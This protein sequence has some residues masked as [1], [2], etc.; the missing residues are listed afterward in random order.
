MK[1]QQ[2]NKIKG[3]SKVIDDVSA[4]RAFVMP[5]LFPFLLEEYQ[6][7]GKTEEDLLN[8]IKKASECYKE[9]VALE[10]QKS[11]AVETKAEADKS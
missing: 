2:L 10:K 5:D 1:K 8:D 4:L 11:P 7:S 6:N 9:L 3:R